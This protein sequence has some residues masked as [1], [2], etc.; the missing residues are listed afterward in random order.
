MIKQR[1][2]IDIIIVNYNSTRYLLKCIETL[3]KK[4]KENIKSSIFVQDNASKDNIKCINKY[5]S[6]VIVNCNQ[7]NLG[8]AAAVNQALEK[9]SAPF[10]LLLNPDT[11]IKADFFEPLLNYMEDNPEVGVVGPRIL[12]PDGSVQGS[13]RTFPT[14]LTGLFGRTTMLSRL[15][16]NNRFTRGNIVTIESDGISP[17]AVDWV[18]GACMLA[19][20]KAIDDIGLM[21]E[22]FFLYWEDA[23]WCRRMWKK[24]W[25][26]VY[27]PTANVVHLIGKSS[28]TRHIQSRF[29]FHKS[30][31][32]LFAKY[33]DWSLIKPLAAL[34]LA[35]RFTVVSILY[36]A[37]RPQNFILKLKRTE[38]QTR[39]LTKKIKMLRLMS[40][41]NI[42]GP[43][44]QAQLLA[45]GLNPKKFTSTTVYG[46]I[47][48]YEGNMSYLFD[49]SK[50]KPLV[51]K[52]LQRE[53]DP[54]M[55]ISAFFKTV[56]IINQLKPDIVHSHMA[57]A[58]FV[59]RLAALI[60]NFISGKKIKMVHTYHGHVFRGY[61]SKT[62]SNIYIFIERILAK[63]TDY[64]IAVSATQKKEL[65][66]EFKIA[67]E[68]KVK[69]IEL[70]FDLAPFMNN[71]HLKGNFR[72]KLGLKD[73]SFL[74]GIVG[75]LAAIKNHKMLFKA[76]KIFIK[77]NLG[78]KIAFIVIGD[79]ELRN[80][81][82]LY[83]QNENISDRVIFYGWVKDVASVY[84]DLDALA[85]TSINEGTPVSI[86][87]AMAS[88][89][90]VIATNA[91]GV[92]D[93]LGSHSDGHPHLNGFKIC[94]RGILCRIND[95][96][97]FANGLKWLIENYKTPAEKK[98]VEKAKKF[99]E[100]RYT[101]T[102][103]I[104]DIEKLYTD[105]VN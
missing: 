2:N 34:V 93:L 27:F 103:L 82:E 26:V 21:D 16:P 43:S 53:I 59:G 28:D 4:L 29:E 80:E 96:S 44:I 25:K 68:N 101:N 98:L 66:E 61:F 23:D 91:G 64:I 22:Q 42:G 75:R 49:S 31:Y 94:D 102:R 38:A 40:R 92:I 89:V 30:G 48:A 11:G 81:L 55:D 7:T 74:V 6:D 88:S 57:K 79:G 90:P 78:V 52:Q 84:A 51:I 100:Q 20:R 58:G 47:S 37:R 3:K 39:S 99:V 15:F 71:E 87:E 54:L 69:T 9:S 13:A 10:I 63:F 86:I 72:Q 97:G 1:A 46:N 95:P 77:Q 50:V 35:F 18:S 104:N 45:H 33:T 62:V 8:F 67:P 56:K 41:L 73:D 83:C 76:V 65:V 17:R 60:V 5:Y 105:L 36:L 85:L 32:R 12:N 24:G 14:L 19:R 70:G